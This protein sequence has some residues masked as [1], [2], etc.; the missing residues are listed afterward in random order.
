MK[1]KIG[2]RVTREVYMDNGVWERFGD[3]CLQHSPL[4]HGVIA[5]VQGQEIT[6]EWDMHGVSRYLEHG[7]NHENALDNT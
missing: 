6:V 3:K 4:K 1:W 2:D 5:E 7:I